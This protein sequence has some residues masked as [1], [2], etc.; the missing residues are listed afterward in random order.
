MVGN[1]KLEI[2][3]LKLNLKLQSTNFK[4]NR[5]YIALTMVMIIGAVSI[6]ITSTLLL[7]GI[8]YSKTATSVVSGQEARG[9]AEACVEDALRAI[10]QDT[11][12]TTSS[13]VVINFT[14]G[15]CNY[16]VTGAP[17]TKTITATGTSG[18]ATKR[19]TVTTSQTT[20]TITV[21]SWQ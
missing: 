21:N 4:L 3:N 8:A 18:N 17:P 9:F 2:R 13:N 15:S 16:S 1:L 12:Y 20:P 19:L 11:T 7:L 6:A 10:N 14:D 5:G